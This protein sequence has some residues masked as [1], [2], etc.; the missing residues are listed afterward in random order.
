VR[1]ELQ[2]AMLVL[3]ERYRWLKAR[4]NAKREVGWETQWDEREA[5]ALWSV[6]RHLADA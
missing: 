4:I 3:H 5:A 6:L 2:E 1:D